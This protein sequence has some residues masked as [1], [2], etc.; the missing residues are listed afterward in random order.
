M[1]TENTSKTQDTIDNYP[2][3]W[4]AT[5][6]NGETP[7][8]PDETLL[9][10][11]SPA[12]NALYETYQK[13][14]TS[15]ALEALKT[16]K[17]TIPTLAALDI[18]PAVK[19]F[20][21]P[22]L[23]KLPPTEYLADGEL[24]AGGLNVL[25]GASGAGKSFVAL[26]Y[27]LRIAQTDVVIFGAAEGG[28]GIQNRVKAWCKHHGKQP[29][30]IRFAIEAVNLLDNLAVDMFIASITALKPKLVVIDTLAR[31]MVG[32]DENSARDMG[33]AIDN[34]N[35]IQRET[36]AAVLLVHHTGKS[37][38]NERGSSALRGA[39]DM[40]I[41]LTSD[42]D[43]I[44]LSCSKSKDTAGF[45][46][47]YLRMVK[48]NTDT[49]ESVVL[50]PSNKVVRDDAALTP[51]QQSIIEWLATKVFDEGARSNDLQ[52]ATGLSGSSF[53]NALNSLSRRDLIEKEGKY[54]PWFLTSDGKKLAG[55]YGWA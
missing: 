48:V 40:M 32:G 35:R 28:S 1:I 51:N 55:E 37:G 26:D 17:T 16:L 31:S 54:D 44:K 12:F 41:E 36:G 2:R 49:G 47:R 6:R 15:A 45:E 39:A 21:F 19:L 33:K 24:V 42:G 13:H 29:G 25:F 46:T 50:L 38:S 18:E 5:L 20:T 23:C 14:G 11:L 22:E 9:N 53:Y 34:C 43:V 10:D 30:N 4:L 7:D 52:K 8:K 27:A 3:E